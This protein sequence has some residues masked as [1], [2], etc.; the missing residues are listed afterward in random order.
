M[1]EKENEQPEE[2]KQTDKET[3]VFKKIEEVFREYHL[4]GIQAT[5]AQVFFQ[6]KIADPSN[7]RVDHVR[8]WMLNKING[9]KHP[10]GFHE[11]QRGCP[12][13]VPGL[14]S[15]PFWDTSEFPW[16]KELEANYEVIKEELLSLRSQS[17]F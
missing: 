16:V 15:Q 6:S 2:A 5:A 13:L 17:G 7:S 4:S 9:I 14:R 1:Q 11:K 3:L 12:D 8:Q 10:K